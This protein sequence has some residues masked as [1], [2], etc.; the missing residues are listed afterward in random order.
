M[1]S[2]ICGTRRLSSVAAAAR[3]HGSLI[4][5]RTVNTLHRP[6]LAPL[7]LR[8]RFRRAENS[9]TFAWTPPE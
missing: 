3:L 6:R 1:R 9:A 2:E 7:L 5:G 8:A 4:L